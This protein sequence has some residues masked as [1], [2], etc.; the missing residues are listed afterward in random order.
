[1]CGPRSSERLLLACVR[2]GR[3]PV[4]IEMLLR[5]DLDWERFLN[6]AT[7]HGVAP[8]VYSTLKRAADRGTVP[9]AVMELLARLYYQQAA[10]NGHL[11]AE[12]RKILEACAR[13][14][15]PVLVLKGAAIA[16]RVYGNIA[17]RPMR[18]LDL[19][20]RRNDLEATDHLLRGLGHVPDESNQSA[21][22]YRDHHHHLALYGAPDGRAAVE[23]HH[24]I[25]APTPPVPIP[26]E[27]LWRRA[28]PTT[29]GV[30]ALALCPE[31]LLLHLCLH[32]SLNHQFSLG[33]RPI[34]DIAQTVRYYGD[35]IDWEQVR[36]RAGQWAVGKY[37][38]LTLRLARDLVD[39][40]VPE[41][42]LDSLQ[43]EGFNPYVIVWARAQIFAVE[44]RI[45]PLSANL[46]QLRGPKRLRDKGA[47]LLRS[48]VPSPKVMARLYPASPDSK[49]IY[50]YYPVRW[51]DLL[52]QYGRS[53]W[54]LLWRDDA[55]MLLA[56]RENQKTALRQWLAWVQ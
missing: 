43:P 22:W 14:G 7:H 26:I 15:I 23:L 38:Y 1:M 3:D 33:L 28:R 17:L 31:D 36:H 2:R 40:T 13:A 44:P 45:L 24:H 46:A 5:S 35:E 20:V 53:A 29:A 4:E 37:V 21:A 27:D 52:W 47:L 9:P 50:L 32:A 16:E 49:R 51:R 11:Y 10:V 55:M 8:L 39:A 19:L 12:L 30:G 25:V 34:C 6:D 54:R 41:E 18:D 56:E 42:L 48:A